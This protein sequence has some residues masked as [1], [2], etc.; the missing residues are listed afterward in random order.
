MA[1]AKGKSMATAH[2]PSEI[3][4]RTVARRAVEAAN[5]GIPAV[6]YDLMLQSLVRDAGGAINQVAY[7]S[8]LPSWKNQTLTP[9]PDAIYFMPFFSTADTGPV[10]LEIP[11]ADEGS[12]TGSVMD[13]WQVAL[14]DVGPAGVDKGK[15]G[16]YLILPPG[17][18]DPV[19]PGYLP[20]PSVRYQ[21]YALLRSILK[22]RSAVD[23]KRA[24][25]YGRRIR[26]YP[27]SKAA[28]PPATKFVDVIDVLFDGVIPYDVR[29]FESL[30][31]MVQ[32]EPWIERDR[33]MI[34]LLK[35]IGIEK[36]KLFRPDART[37]TLL[38][39]AA[40]EA[41]TR[42][43]LLYE[44]SY[45]PHAK[46]ARWFLP[47]DKT[48]LDAVGHDFNEP[49]TYPIDGRAT[50]YYFAFSS[51]KHMGAGQFY[52][53]VS[54]DKAGRLLDGSK[55][56]RLRV[57]PKPP[58]RQYWSV[59]LYDFAT[60]ALIRRMP[61]SSRSSLEPDLQTNDDGSVDVYFGPKAP[62]GLKSNWIPTSTRGR[63]EAL[64]RFYG[65]DKPLFDKSWVLPDIEK[66]R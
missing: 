28:K 59:V 55:T 36:G 51:V 21:G 64:F 3:V 57:P 22:S 16:K 27:L 66:I 32:S 12:I 46:G 17:H 24:V 10:V 42:F 39:S 8:G 29:F 47:A 1:K 35:S 40:L 52:L 45:E 38:K 53:F 18:K 6:N 49:D 9:N 62:A 23:V 60:H 7:W 54:R 58:V 41:R 25:D 4:R 43:D 30:D 15:G 31:R 61:W 63:F 44:T 50:A 13:S 11:P 48:L 26:L 34:D 14:E 33:V 65:P 19:P 37:K 56:Y 2:S 20:L 5:W